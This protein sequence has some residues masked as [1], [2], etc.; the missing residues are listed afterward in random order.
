MKKITSIILIVT[1][2]LSICT[3]TAYAHDNSSE[4][5]FD[6]NISVLVVG[7]YNFTT[8][9]NLSDNTLN[10]PSV[11]SENNS[12][13]DFSDHVLYTDSLCSSVST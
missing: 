6:E 13:F 12:T 1:L 10:A 8:Q 3:C 9:Y 11:T 5:P 4:Q 7:N 2:L